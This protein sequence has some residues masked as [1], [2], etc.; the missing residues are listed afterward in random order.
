[1]N[2]NLVF[3]GMVERKT[4]GEKSMK[5][6]KVFVI[7]KENGEVDFQGEAIAKT[8]M[9]AFQKSKASSYMNSVNWEEFEVGFA[10]INIVDQFD[11][12]IRL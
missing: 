2:E 4:K 12:D 10:E 6:F 3:S 7:E 8:K 1:V 5:L 9:E 11:N